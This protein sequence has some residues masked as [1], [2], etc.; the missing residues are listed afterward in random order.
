[1]RTRYLQ[2]FGLVF[3]T[4]CISTSSSYQ[5]ELKKLRGNWRLVY[6]QIDG[7][8]L[9]DEQAARMFNGRMTFTGNKAV[10]AADLPGFYF[11]FKFRIDATRATPHDR[12]GNTA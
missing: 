9:P 3:L 5:G 2:F 12:S 7:H 6:Q 11:E 1:M 10:Y 8:K 4:G